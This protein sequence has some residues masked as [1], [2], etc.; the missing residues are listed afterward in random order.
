MRTS[1][2]SYRIRIGQESD[3]TVLDQGLMFQYQ[4]CFNP[5]IRIEIHL[6]S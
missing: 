3:K 1:N 6:I 5:E 4:F 2:G